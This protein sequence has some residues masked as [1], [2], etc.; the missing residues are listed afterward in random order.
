MVR[1][2]AVHVWAANHLARQR[3]LAVT[4]LLS[5]AAD[6][7]DAQEKAFAGGS[8]AGERLRRDSGAY[9]RALDLAVREGAALLREAG[10]PVAEETLRRVRDVLAGAAL[11]GDELRRRLGSGILVEEPPPPG[12]AAFSFAGALPE[13]PA[14]APGVPRAKSAA[15]RAAPAP[16]PDRAEHHRLLEARKAAETTAEAAK[17]LAQVARRARRR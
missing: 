12:A 8:G 17:R 7:S 6:L 1:K 14:P 13:R 16:G 4:R 2:P 3:G 11:G 5:A 15:P 10:R 9:L